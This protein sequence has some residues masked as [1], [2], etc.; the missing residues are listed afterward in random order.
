[1]RHAQQRPLSRRRRGVPARRPRAD[2]PSFLQE[3]R[4]LRLVERVE[5]RVFWMQ[6]VTIR[7]AKARPSGLIPI[8][9]GKFKFGVLEPGDALAD[10][11][12]F[13]FP[14]DEDEFATWRG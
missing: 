12:D 3:V 9:Q 5:L 7:A 8:P 4:P 13:L 6:K 1:M 11:P 14:M 10:G 2:G